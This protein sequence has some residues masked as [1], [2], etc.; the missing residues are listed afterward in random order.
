M[1]T[2]DLDIP[3]LNNQFCSTSIKNHPGNQQLCLHANSMIS[4]TKL[5]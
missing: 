4:L 2:D 1:P 3:L 5:A